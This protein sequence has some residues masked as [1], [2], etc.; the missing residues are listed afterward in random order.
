MEMQP[1]NPQRTSPLI[2]IAA[3]AVIVMSLVGV[4]V[5]TGLI[6]SAMSTHNDTPAAAV[7]ATGPNSTVSSTTTTTTT[8]KPAPR[9]PAQPYYTPPAPKA[10]P[11]PVVAAICAT[12]GRVESI[13][14]IET[15]GK[16]SG[17]GA[18][19]GG[20]GG[21]LLGNQVG[22]GNGKTVATVAGVVGGALIGN[23]VE[24]RVKKEVSYRV[25]VRMED[26]SARTFDQATAG[27]YSVGQRVKLDNGSW[28]NA[29]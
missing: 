29:G 27:G 24:K 28:V 25:H 23:E 21:G 8:T 2:P 7:T 5:F 19:A 4:G 17:I 12:C 15:K 6:P 22:G 18:V 11:A 1:N 14:T 13:E 16:G 10:A 3:G 9:A 26:G 20:V